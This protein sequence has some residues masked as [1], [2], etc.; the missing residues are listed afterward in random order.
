MNSPYTLITAHSGCNN[1]PPDT[2]ESVV[3]GIESGADFVEVDIRSTKD[4]TAILY[5]NDLLI[6]KEYGAVR[7]N[8]ITLSELNRLLEI[9]S[10]TNDQVPEITTFGDVISLVKDYNGSIN[11]DIKDDFCI[12]P[13]VKAVRDADM[14]D[15]VI[16]TGCEHDRAAS[17]KK[18]YPEFQ[19]LLNLNENLLLDKQKSAS[20]I[21]ET[22]C[23][24]AVE[25]ACCGIN[26]NYTYLTDEL[27]LLARKRYLPISIWTLSEHDD[28]DAYLDMGLYSITTMTASLLVEKR[29]EHMKKM[30]LLGV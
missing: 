21:S 10:M 24:M 5:H 9:D 13:I 30:V 17:L 12:G 7:I 27:I 6:T 26:I 3:S 19:V 8:D 15:S 2:L 25:A 4:G 20:M 28:L 18:S 11:I 14:V 23:D 16:L 29:K 1:S 22:I